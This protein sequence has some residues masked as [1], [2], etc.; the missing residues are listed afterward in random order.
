MADNIYVY[1]REMSNV[2]FSEKKRQMLKNQLCNQLTFLLILSVLCKTYKRDG[3]T[4]GIIFFSVTN[5]IGS[6]ISVM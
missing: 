3:G 1:S 2:I 6:E 4:F 5:A